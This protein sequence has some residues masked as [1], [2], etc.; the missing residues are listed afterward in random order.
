MFTVRHLLHI[1]F[2]SNKHVWCIY[3]TYLQVVH[4][5]FTLGFRVS[6]FFLI[7]ITSSLLIL[8]RFG[9]RFGSEWNIEDFTHLFHNFCFITL[10]QAIITL[11]DVS[12]NKLLSTTPSKVDI[13]CPLLH[14]FVMDAST[15]GSGCVKW[16]SKCIHRPSLRFESIFSFIIENENIMFNCLTIRY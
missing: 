14:N 16:V 1:N 8:L 5:V 10:P 2:M 4:L 6:R 9:S 12:K 15:I 3:V 13:R 11:L 7:N